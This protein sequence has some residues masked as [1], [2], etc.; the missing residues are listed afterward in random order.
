M[1]AAL[2]SSHCIWR[3]YGFLRVVHGCLATHG[4]ISKEE[5]QDSIAPPPYLAKSIDNDVFTFL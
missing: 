5:Q 1:L 2:L 4:L 3:H